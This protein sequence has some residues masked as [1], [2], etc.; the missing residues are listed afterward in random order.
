MAGTLL[1]HAKKPIN[2]FFNDTSLKEINNRQIP[3][4]KVLHIKEI[5][6]SFFRM[7]ELHPRRDFMIVQQ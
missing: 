7:H 1:W 4:A 2:R 3:G 6:L 5:L